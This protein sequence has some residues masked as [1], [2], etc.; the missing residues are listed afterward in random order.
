MKNLG[1][2]G[3]TFD[4]VHNTHISIAT[5]AMKQYNLSKIL[6]MPV[7]APTH[8]A[9]AI[10][11]GNARLDMVRLAIKGINGLEASDFELTR[12]GKSYTSDTLLLLR[13][14]YSDCRLFF[15]IGG[16]SVMY[17]EKWHKPEIIFENSHILYACRKG[18]GRY[19]VKNHIET[20][21]NKNFKNIEISEIVMEESGTASTEIRRKIAEGCKNYR[22]LGLPESVFD[23]IVKNGLYR[24]K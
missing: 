23:Y 9:E 15:I 16:D 5:A 10:A 8:K 3:G 19:E 22:E 24:K 21:L 20:V 11:D 12:E 18:D 14:K 6:M 2:L 13:K 1:V 7:K 4:P 17:L